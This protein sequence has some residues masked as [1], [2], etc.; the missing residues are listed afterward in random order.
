MH[1][2][3]VYNDIFPPVPGGIEKHIDLIRKSLPD[4]HTDVLVCARSRTSSWARQGTGIEVKV[5]ELGPRVWSVP[6]APSLPLRLRKMSADVVH[7]HMPNPLGELA[8]LA[9]R[10][11]PLVCSYHADVVRQARVAPVYRKLVQACLQRAETVIVGSRRL[12]DTSPFLGRHAERAEVV[13]YFI[14]TDAISR[15]HASEREL[16]SLRARYGPPI[17][18]AVARLV[19]YKGLDV[20]IE[21][22]HGLEASVVIVGTGPLAERLRQLA[23]AT[24]NVHFAGEVSERELLNYL[25]AADCFVLP[26]TS[27]AESFGISVLEAQAMSLPAVVT[28]VG[29][30]TVE[31]IS[32]GQTGLVVRPRDANAL[33][34]AIAE[35]L[36]DDQRREMMG[37]NAR[38]RVVA[39][40]SAPRG[41]QRLHDIYASAIPIAAK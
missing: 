9:D 20:L 14:D 5:A 2:L 23:R 7:L 33:R 36:S 40:H 29:T 38:K 30:G 12:A 28:D 13:P 27:R 24:S 32:P 17:V 22:A 11:R 18:L 34:E 8:V 4:V 3:H 37:V 6:I 16:A 21:A 15:E 41:A 35:I 19:Y 1:V 31:A 10:S 25:A 26:S 39:R